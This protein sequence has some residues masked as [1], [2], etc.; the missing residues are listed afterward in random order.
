[1]KNRILKV[2]FYL[3]AI[4]VFT[5]GLFP[6]IKMFEQARTPHRMDY[7]DESYF[8]YHVI[9]AII[10][11]LGSIAGAVSLIWMAHRFKTK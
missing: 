5:G 2:A 6:V 11:L 3:V 10:F 1:M 8:N 9:L 7:N 4:V